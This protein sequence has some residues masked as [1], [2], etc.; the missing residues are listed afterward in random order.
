MNH[1]LEIDTMTPKSWFHRNA[2]AETLPGSNQSNKVTEIILIL[3]IVGTLSQ[4]LALVFA[5]TIYTK[6]NLQ[7]IIKLYINLFF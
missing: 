6:K 2:Q 3:E 4:V 5:S 1:L 7:S